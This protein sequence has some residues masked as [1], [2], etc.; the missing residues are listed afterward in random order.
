M[1]G[2]SYD[3]DIAIDDVILVD[4]EC[5][6]PGSCDFEDD[7]C[8]WTNSHDGD[9]NFDWIRHT[10][11]TDSFNTGP[12]ADHTEGNDKGKSLPLSLQM[13]ARDWL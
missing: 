7:T 11:S 9:D 4:D 3:G 1:R 10:G 12:T 6:P 5:P 8:T 13:A 2:T